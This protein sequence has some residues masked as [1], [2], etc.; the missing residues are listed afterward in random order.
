M[1]KISIVFFSVYFVLSAFGQGNPPAKI[2]EITNYREV[3]SSIEYPISSRLNSVEGKVV[4]ALNIDANGSI[5]SYEFT[6]YP[7]N[8]LKVAV[9]D[10]LENFNIKPAKDESGRNIASKLAIPVVFELT[11]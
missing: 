2:A 8:E 6:S 9:E 4:V 10:A 1:K 3:V 7:C 5:S 11:I